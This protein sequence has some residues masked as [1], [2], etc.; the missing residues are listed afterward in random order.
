MNKPDQLSLFFFPLK[1]KNLQ[2]QSNDGHCGNIE[3]SSSSS[4]F[5]FLKSSPSRSSS[6]ETEEE[7]LTLAVLCGPGDFSM[8]SA[9]MAMLRIR[10]FFFFAGPC[11]HIHASTNRHKSTHAYHG[12]FAHYGISK[13]LVVWIVIDPRALCI[14]PKFS[15]FFKPLVDWN[16]SKFICFFFVSKWEDAGWIAYLMV[17]CFLWNLIR[18]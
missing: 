14:F 15:K 10:T 3:R 18:N 12:P 6:F 4:T 11:M 1:R 9:C 7:A 8:M 13:P 5:T 2:W 17:L 16:S